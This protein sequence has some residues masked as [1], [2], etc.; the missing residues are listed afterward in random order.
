MKLLSFDVAAGN[1]R[2]SNNIHKPSIIVFATSIHKGIDNLNIFISDHVMSS[3]LLVIFD[4][5]ENDHTK[6]HE[7]ITDNIFIVAAPDSCHLP[8][9]HEM[10]F[11]CCSVDNAFPVFMKKDSIN[12]FIS[13]LFDGRILRLIK[14]LPSFSFCFGL[15]FDKKMIQF[16]THPNIKIVNYESQTAKYTL[17]KAKNDALNEEKAK[18]ALLINMFYAQKILD[19]PNFIRKTL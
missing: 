12:S 5:N 2:E 14:S 13:S 3:V 10:D 15:L 19:I 9:A 4:D 8:D 1:F 18:A 17:W 7:M 6:L 16:S 11:V